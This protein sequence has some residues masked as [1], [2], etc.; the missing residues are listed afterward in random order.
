MKFRTIA[1]W[2]VFAHVLACS[3]QNYYFRTVTVKDGLADNFIRNIVRDSYGYIWFSTIHGISR[4]DGYRFSNYMPLD[5]GGRSNDVNSVLE[6]GDSTLW[7]NCAGELF[8]FH[9]SSGTWKKDG[10]EHLSKLGVKG[11]VKLLHVDDRHNLWVNTEYGLFHYDYSQRHVIQFNLYSKSPLSHIV[12]QNGYTVVINSDNKIYEVALRERRLVPLSQAP[13]PTGS[14]DSHAFLDSN[15]DLWVY[16]SLSLAG[17]QW[18]FSKKT[19]QWQQ[20]T[21]LLQLG[22]VIVNIIT[23]DHDGN[24]WVG[25]SNAGIFILPLQGSGRGKAQNV[26]AFLP[27]S[28]HITCLYPDANNT[29][30]VG[31]A[32]LGAAMTDMSSPN[33]N[34]V[35]TGDHEDV[36][37]LVEDHSGNLWI[38]FDGGGV[39]MKT[40]EGATRHF[41]SLQHQLPSDIVTALTVLGDGTLLVGTYDKGIA[42]Y[43]GSRFVPIYSEYPV[44]RYIKTMT[45]DTR[46]NLWVATVDKGVVRVGTDGKVT[47]YTSQNSPL[48]FNGTLCL[49]CD[50][51]REMVYIGTSLGVSAYDV[52]H[53]KFIE[54]QQL[55]SLRGSYVS[56]LMMCEH[57]QLWIGSRNGLWICNPQEGPVTHL[58]TEQGM[59]HNAVRSLA[60][61]GDHV[62]A[63]TDNGLTCISTVHDA[64]HKPPYSCFP[65]FDSDGLH[66]VLFSNDASLTTTGGMA[67]LGSFS[68]YVRILPEN[69]PTAY[70]QLR[71]Q[72]TGAWI[73]GETVEEDF[74]SFTLR[75]NDRLGVSVSAMVPAL[76]HKIRYL[77]RFK[78]EE[79]WMS[80]PDNILYFASLKPGSH[81]LQVKGELPG[82]MESDIVE[83]PINVRPPFFLTN[84]AFFIYLLV[85][86]ALVYYLNKLMRR[87]QKRELA[88]KQMEVNLKKYEMD[89]EKI[90]FFT[91]ISHDLKTPLTLVVAPL[92]KIRKLSLPAPIRTEV[93]VAWRNARQLYDL[94]LQ[95]LDFRRLDVGREK[96]HLRHGDIV[97]F[98]RQTVENFDYYAMNKQIKMQLQLPQESI[99]I[100]FDEDKLRRII[101]NLL[102]N[103]FKYNTDKGTVTVALDV[104][105]DLQA[106]ERK[107]ILTV[108]DTGIGVKDK[109]RIFERFAQES[110]GQEQEGN[111][112]GLHIVRQYVNMMKGDISVSDNKP[113]GTVF[114][115][116]LPVMEPAEEDTEKEKMKTDSSIPEEEMGA[117]APNGKPTLLVVDD[118]MDARMFLQ[119]SLDDEYQVLVAAN[120]KEALSVL[121]KNDNVDI[122]ISDVMMPVMD[123]MTLFQRLKSNIRYSH[124]PVILLTAKSSE[125]NI[126]EGLEKGAADYITK[127]FSLDVLRLRIRKIIEWTQDVH[128]RVASGMEIKPSDITVS[129]LDEEFISNVIANIEANIQDVN[130]S[131]VQLSTA[132]GLTRGHLYKKLMAIT[133][134]SPIEFIRIIKLKRG[135]SLL[136][137]GKTNISEVAD[138]VGFSAKQ[139]AHYFKM[140]YDDTPSEY[141]KKRKNS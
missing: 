14:R 18:A 137:Q 6:T 66:N 5:F 86:A 78:D 133:G 101:T 77:Y 106:E 31:S 84:L 35:S 20:Q 121:A 19:R 113:R 22:P 59:S 104:G 67:L 51:L 136:D 4:Y 98:V 29:M 44:L 12:S 26:N 17:S 57:G 140:N 15:G 30:W 129:S 56:S 24:L 16:N 34:V 75:H 36:S 48:L 102:S 82:M 68:G 125:E 135:K 42:R 85:F 91:N 90:R 107:V 131:V 88:M 43:D 60:K 118:N 25:T 70:P 127:P 55:D 79:E 134:K 46:G 64:S 110:H 62:W 37:S 54:S 93:D 92:E 7:M 74:T 49:A 47:N 123:G 126:V 80:A 53:N 3:A 100:D 40:R 95:L 63:S 103:A 128:T 33:F 112:L 58:T 130:Y 114:T 89:E 120:G 13:G 1:L 8:T 39:M 38:G 52:A 65:F 117:E 50:S 116:T 99:E 141:L 105:P 111:G 2:L 23:E 96:L 81:V 61:S 132:V 124:I 9:R 108:A 94:V 87:R 41:S 97:N 28:S 45:A 72:Y 73:N 11:T 138:M 109:R 122:V 83:L 115:V 10:Q 71:M 69:F 32:K 139:F 76:S 119:R 27:R 21:D